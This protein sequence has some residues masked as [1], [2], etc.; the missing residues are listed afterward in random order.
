MPV[1]IGLLAHAG[2]P[3][4]GVDEVQ[5]IVL[6]GTPTGGTFT[7]TFDGEDT[8]EIAFD[9]TAAAVQ[10]ALEALTTVAGVR[11]SYRGAANGTLLQDTT[12]ALLYI[13]TGTAKRPIWSDLSMVDV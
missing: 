11:A 6:T 1:T 13:N 5:T 9:A 10:A 4:D 8:D 2:T 12:N 7:I 3:T